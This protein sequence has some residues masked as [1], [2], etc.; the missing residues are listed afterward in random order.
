MQKILVV[1]D[2]ED[3]VETLER[4]FSFYQYKVIKALNGKIAVGKAEKEHPDIIILDA[5]MPV[6]NGF[7]A[8]RIL[9]DKKKTKEIP[10]VILTAR[11]VDQKSRENGLKI[12]ADD[13]LV[14]PFNS[15]ELV[16]RIKTLLQKFQMMRALKRENVEL[17]NIQKQVSRELEKIPESNASQQENLAIDQLT[18]LYSTKYLWERLKESA[19]S[20]R[21]AMHPE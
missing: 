8:C 5:H 21:G 15:K 4:L 16:S 20:P 2:N 1:D 14:K 7:E 3:M 12:G 17:T 11:Y 10:I 13:Y 9:K 18:G 6:M 19:S